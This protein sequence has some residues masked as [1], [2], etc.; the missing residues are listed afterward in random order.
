LNCLC[1]SRLPE[2]L[3]K[4]VEESGTYTWEI[5]ETLDVLAR[6]STDCEMLAGVL[7]AAMDAISQAIYTSEADFLMGVIGHA[8]DSISKNCAGEEKTITGSIFPSS[9]AGSVSFKLN[10]DVAPPTEDVV[11]ATIA[12]L[13]AGKAGIEWYDYGE[14]FWAWEVISGK[15]K[16]GT[17]YTMGT[18]V[19]SHYQITL[20]TIAV[21][22]LVA[23]LTL[24]GQA[25]WEGRAIDELKKDNPPFQFPDDNDVS[26]FAG[27][28]FDWEV[29][30]NLN[31]HFDSIE[32]A[33]ATILF[34]GTH[35]GKITIWDD[36][37]IIAKFREGNY[38]LVTNSSPSEAG[39]VQPA[40]QT[41]YP[42]GTSVK[43]SANANE[44]WQFQKWSIDA[45]GIVSPV[46]V[47]MDDDKTVTAV[48]QK[49]W[50]LKTA[51]LPPEGGVTSPTEIEVPDGT[52]V[53]IVARANEGFLFSLWKDAETGEIMAPAET[54][55]ISVDD[56]ISLLAVFDKAYT[57]TTSINIP[58]S[59]IVWPAGE[60]RHKEGAEVE[61]KADPAPGFDF[62]EWS[63]DASGRSTTIV[64]TMDSNKGVIA[65]FIKQLKLTTAVSPPEMGAI[66]PTGETFW[67]EDEVA[68]ITT[69]PVK[70]HDFNYFSIVPEGLPETM[71]EENPLLWQMVSDVVVT[72]VLH[73]PVTLITSTGEGGDISPLGET[74]YRY[75][76][77]AIIT[78]S[79][80]TGYY[81]DIWTG[82]ASGMTNPLSLPMDGDKTVA[83]TFQ[84]WIILT[85]EAGKGG[86]V[87]LE[88]VTKWRRDDEV[89]VV[90]TPEA[91]FLFDIWSGDVE[92]TE[93][94]IKFIIAEDMTIKANFVPKRTLV[95]A[96]TKGGST[97]PSGTMELKDSSTIQ[98]KAIPL[99]GFSFLKWSG[100]IESTANP[101]EIIMDDDKNIT[102]EFLDKY[103]LTTTAIPAEGGTVS[104]SGETD[105][106]QGESVRISATSISDFEFAGWSGDVYGSETPITVVMDSDKTVTANFSKMVTIT[107][108]VEGNG[109]ISVPQEFKVAAGTDLVIHATPDSGWWLTNWIVGVVDTGAINPLQY[110]ITEDI[111]ITAFFKQYFELTTDVSPD[112]EKPVGSVIPSG[113]TL[114]SKDTGV[115]CAASGTP[116]TQVE[117]A[118]VFTY[119]SGDIEGDVTW[120]PGLVAMDDNKEITAHF[121]RQYRLTIKVN[122]KGR[123]EPAEFA[124][125]FPDETA[126]A[127]AI[128]ADVP[129]GMFLYWTGDFTGLSNPAVVAMT[130]NKTIMAHFST[131]G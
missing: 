74:T 98:V 19:L 66:S 73:P 93:A 76:E 119:W 51:P 7:E 2:D 104:P 39:S 71:S 105:Y 89:N 84:E 57:L 112:E 75:E 100:D 114:W 8:G 38:F 113:T 79:P 33:G 23:G 61:I 90:A 64:I 72:A 126:Y 48:F 110:Y 31:W 17:K 34:D 9:D 128:S 5:L 14:T 30:E 116:G 108:S 35:N 50:I 13:V 122:G 46:E 29:T 42:P 65:D 27:L 12:L 47:L 26:T 67:Y 109:T 85:T 15:S 94:S 92:N 45:T 44:G 103:K 87:S 129:G 54:A 55:T 86:N 99:I 88:R 62:V 68:T 52:P 107:T 124:F 58:E 130:R 81:F 22:A 82:D 20:F 1:K 3:R 91:D 96:A 127:Y 78:A 56:D 43:V 36:T 10:L 21:S 40:G 18:Y 32:A 80:D 83:A 41:P 49:V 11:R 60:T 63:G 28:T 131:P 16:L 102:A 111:H 95:I 123:T 24:L 37:T 121:L 115:W 120:N 6:T 53:E 118:F 69:D 4:Q 125:Y 106:L 59:G 25:I 101:V 97:S 77:I 70:Q 117:P